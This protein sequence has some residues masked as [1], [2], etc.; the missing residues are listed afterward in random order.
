VATIADEAVSTSRDL[1]TLVTADRQRVIHHTGV[2][3]LAVQVFERLPSRPIVTAPWVVEALS[4]TKP[5][6]GRAIEALEGAGVLV[7]TTGKKRDRVYA[8]QAYLD[9]LRG[10]TELGDEG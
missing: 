9:R 4:T 6:A 10:G 1:F 8:Y 3:L 7:E 5:T 2:N